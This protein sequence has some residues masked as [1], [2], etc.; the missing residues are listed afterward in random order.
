M[1]R[2]ISLLQ[3]G[4]DT[5]NS[6]NTSFSTNNN[7]KKFFKPLV[8]S[9]LA[10]FLS[11]SNINAA[12]SNDTGFYK[13]SGSNRGE[14]INFNS[15]NVTFKDVSISGSNGYKG[16]S[17]DS[18][19]GVKN[20]FK[21]YFTG[22][23]NKWDSN[24]FS[25]KGQLDL[26]QDTIF[27]STSGIA[28]GSNGTG[29]LTVDM[30]TAENDNTDR[31]FT[32][33]L[34]GVTTTY[35]F[36]GN[37]AVTGSYNGTS[38]NYSHKT[39]N[40][41]FGGKGIKG[42]VTLN[43]LGNTNLEFKQGANI[44]GIITA[45]NGQATIKASDT[46]TITNIRHG[47]STT[48]ATITFDKSANASSLEVKTNIGGIGN[49][50]YNAGALKINFNNETKLTGN[51]Q[52]GNADNAN[53][54]VK[55]EV[56]FNGATTSADT[57]V[58]KGNIISYGTGYGNVPPDENRG[59][60]VTFTKGSLQGNIEARGRNSRSGFNKVVF[61]DT[62]GGQK[63]KGSVLAN[64]AT[65]QAKNSVSFSSA[66]S[67][68][69]N[70]E[71]N[72]GI[73]II[74]FGATNGDNSI[75]GNITAAPPGQN[76]IT[77]SGNN[78]SIGGSVSTTG[79]TNTITFEASSNGEQKNTIGGI[80]ASA[81]INKIIFDASNSD[82]I[83]KNN[84]TA[85]AS[86]GY[87]DVYNIITSKSGITFENT[88][89]ISTGISNGWGSNVKNI[90]DI[91]GT[92]TFKNDV[93][94]VNKSAS[95]WS[96]SNV[97][98]ILKFNGDVSFEN[99]KKIIEIT[100]SGSWQ[101]FVNGI[102]SINILSFEGTNSQNITVGDINKGADNTGN[103]YIGKNITTGSEKNLK[104]IDNFATNWSNAEYQANLNLT[105]ENGIFTN[106]GANY[107]NVKQLTANTITANGGS[108][109][110][111]TD[112]SDIKGNISTS[113]GTNTIIANNGGITIAG[114]IS[115]SSGTNTITVNN[116]DSTLAINGSITNNAGT[117]TI[118][119]ENGTIT[120]TKTGGKIETSGGWVATNTITAKN[121]TI[122]VNS[123]TAVYT[124]NNSKSTNT[125]TATESGNITANITAQNKG[126]NNI[127]IKNTATSTP[128][129]PPVS[130]ISTPTLEQI[131][132]G[133]KSLSSLTGNITTNGG[134]NNIVF[135]NKIW[136]PS[137]VKVSNNIMNLEGISSGTLTTTGGTTNLV[138]R[139]AASSTTNGIIPIY[140]VKTT[141]GTANLVMQGP[142]NVEAD[143]DYGTS[144][145]TN[146][147][148]A[149]NNDGKTADEFKNGVA[150]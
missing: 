109:N 18:G 144:G 19:S 95:A 106:K 130:G 85:N 64:G 97:Y 136:M 68:E 148:F 82:N 78:N 142:V 74:A 46:L 133:L 34:S 52:N 47:V 38:E 81:G 63:I 77:F 17:F 80:N 129:T 87:S 16:F 134:T 36:Y 48:D 99:G 75:T 32:M 15:N 70:V 94:I 107:I 43:A 73:N 123:I 25:N 86:G 101:N 149:S 59:N 127:L 7:S 125:I 135:E 45:T 140:T 93:S 145:I 143:I 69:G 83:I 1:K 60:H 108:N 65:S 62:N 11:A 31:I 112:N 28:M 113:S 96:I 91:T 100:A 42:N 6:L 128:S 90:F 72:A 92:T 89:S 3:G 12:S 54:F 139:Q 66:G 10:L 55:N 120:I 27:Y 30:W 23:E 13:V 122:D 58:M 14:A 98:N 35:A 121:I 116:T 147:I 76:T 24:G 50:S 79:G 119:A 53:D 150:G 61:G 5:N 84:I 21:L 20:E 126:A 71:A 111:V 49:G 44:D 146:L 110:I 37:L 118:K 103:N 33:D 4:G 26:G 105:V 88:S 29:T 132:Q 39:F 41:I 138:L 115:A 131:T 56:S 141:G 102:P 124:N 2:N 137:Q 57:I 117:N 51:I 40:G 22:S 9:S 8:A 114:G 104:L 67:I